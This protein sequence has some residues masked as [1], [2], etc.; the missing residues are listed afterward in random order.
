M[1]LHIYLENVIY[2]LFDVLVVYLMEVDGSCLV[3]EIKR[4]CLKMFNLIN[5]SYYLLIYYNALKLKHLIYL[6]YRYLFY[7]YVIISLYMNIYN[8]INF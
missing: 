3:M 8:N 5:Y 6:Y 7:T 1:L 2:F 4:K